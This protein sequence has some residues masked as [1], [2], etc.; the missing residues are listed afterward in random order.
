MSREISPG[1]GARRVRLW[2]RLSA[3]AMAGTAGVLGGAWPLAGAVL[4]GLAAEANLS[5]LVRALDRAAQW[6]GRSLKGTL[7]RFY[8]TFLATALICFLVVR[9][10]WGHPLAFLAGLMSPV[11]GLI[12][13]LISFAVSPPKAGPGHEH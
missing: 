13:G 3:L 7:A 6:R 9:F 4:G 1:A 12:L 2:A 10:H 8:L 5:I 11:P